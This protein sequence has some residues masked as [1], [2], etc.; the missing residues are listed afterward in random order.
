[1]DLLALISDLKKEN[2]LRPR[3]ITIHE[4]KT[5]LWEITSIELK[6]LALDTTIMVE[7]EDGS[8]TAVPPGDFFT[9]APNTF[10][11]IGA[12]EKTARYLAAA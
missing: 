12:V 3:V 4:D 1:M 10:Y 6:I 11:R 8:E 7:L 9:I 2:Y 5:T